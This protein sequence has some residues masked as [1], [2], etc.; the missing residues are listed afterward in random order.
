MSAERPRNVG[1]KQAGG[2]LFGDWGTSR[3]YVLGLALFFAGRTSFWLILAMSVLIMAVGWAYSQICRIYPDGGG[4]YTAA[5]SKSRT[6]AVVGALLLFADYTVTASL[7]ALDA[8]HYFGLGAE[9]AHVEKGQVDK[10][11]DTDASLDPHRQTPPSTADELFAWRSPALWG[12]VAVAV[13]GMFNLMG[14]KHT[15]GFAIAAAVGMVFI[16]LLITAFALPQVPWAD[17]PQRIPSLSDTLQHQPT[18][19]WVSFVS[20]VL[21]LSGVEAIANLT[22]VMKKPVAHTARKAIWVVATEVAVFNVLLALFMLSISPIDR[23]AHQADMA[24]FLTG[25][26][27]GQW[28]ELAVRIIGGVLLL[29][30]ANT[31]ITD[32]ISVQYLMARDGELPQVMT[33]LNRFGVPWLP[34]VV[35]ASVPI[36]VLL[37]SHDLDSLAALYAIGVIG[38]VAINVTLCAMHPR[39]RRMQRKVPMLVLG[40]I[41]LAIWVTLAFVKR[42]ALLFVTVVMVLGLSARQ[43]NRFLAQ[44]RG[45]KPSILRQAIAEQLPDNVALMPKVLL[46]TYGSEA[47]AAPAFAEAKRI[48]AAV[49]VAFV[50]QV[51][52]SYKYDAA[53]R[54]TIDTDLAALR[55]FARFLDLGHEAGVP[56]IPIYDTGTNAAEL[57]AE[58]AAMY[59]VDRVLI[60][61]SRRGAIHKFIKGN[62]QKQLEYLL[63]PDTKIVVVPPPADG[64][65]HRAD[66]SVDEEALETVGPKT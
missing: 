41:L 40:V 44:R 48:G 50:R 51:N 10:G 35:A 60:G 31:A 4:V 20:I 55:T 17:L 42:E 28:G 9:H 47:L 24:A 66:A 5:K 16:T 54:L 64:L 58:S 37:I 57:L 11:P 25:H 32:M 61:T 21:A 39:L 2:L 45:P 7:S 63:P 38:A 1:W 23:D 49:V 29:S 3:L 19:L 13:I 53:E 46:A 65:P 52:L 14:P 59:G 6:L 34:A 12:I 43:L 30:A 36:I 27:V 15:G 18:A 26:Y 22:G 8:F 56:V 62:F 33:R